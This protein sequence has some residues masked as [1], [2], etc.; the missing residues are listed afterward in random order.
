M[1]AEVTV[2]RPGVSQ[3][4]EP[5]DG[6]F[7]SHR[8]SGKE[9]SRR[10]RPPA[11]PWR[12][13]RRWPRSRPWRS[14]RK[15]GNRTEFGSLPVWRSRSSPGPFPLVH[16]RFDATVL[17]RARHASPSGRF[18]AAG[19][20]DSSCEVRCAW[21]SL[22]EDEVGW[23]GEAK[24]RHA[25]AG[26]QGTVE[27]VG[28]GVA[29]LRRVASGQRPL[30]HSPLASHPSVFGAPGLR[31]RHAHSV[32]E[33]NLVKKCSAIFSSFISPGAGS[34]HGRGTARPLRG[35]T[36]P[37]AFSLASGTGPTNIWA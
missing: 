3:G 14:S 7:R 15:G 1:P 13:R 20:D 11:C 29:G 5:L 18:P 25:A 32:T 28:G 27:W 23:K 34:L 24:S 16:V 22:G 17:P 9:R 12:S 21:C 36:R 10:S 30:V 35:H 4:R 2:T 26:N 31:V 37:R 6:L 33:P 8:G 19:S